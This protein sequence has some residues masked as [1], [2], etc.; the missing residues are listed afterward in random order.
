MSTTDGEFSVLSLPI[1]PRKG[2]GAGWGAAVPDV[3]LPPCGGEW[4]GGLFSRLTGCISS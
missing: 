1:P 2:K 3:H 4:V